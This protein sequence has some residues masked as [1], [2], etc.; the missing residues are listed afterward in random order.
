M[1]TISSDHESQLVAG[2]EGPIPPGHISER[3]EIGFPSDSLNRNFRRVALGHPLLA[4]DLV[5]LNIP[6]V[7]TSE[8]KGC[9]PVRLGMLTTEVIIKAILDF[10]NVNQILRMPFED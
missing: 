5:C 3:R 6:P 9:G 2:T 10:D 1:I 7:P 8:A 4:K